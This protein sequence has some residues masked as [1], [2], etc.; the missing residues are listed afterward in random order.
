[1]KRLILCAIAAL[2]LAV[3]SADAGGFGRSSFGFRSRGFSSFGGGCAV[4]QQ[5]VPVQQFQQFGYQQQFG[6]NGFQQQPVV[7]IQQRPSLLGGLLGRAVFGR[8]RFD[9]GGFGRG[10]FGNRGFGGRGFGRR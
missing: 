3:S 5:F 1:M 9:R 7:V 4:Q 10:G 2:S 8:S 6:F